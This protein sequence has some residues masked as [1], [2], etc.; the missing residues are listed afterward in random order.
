MQWGV[1]V[2][3]LPCAYHSEAGGGVLHCVQHACILPKYL[4]A[5][6]KPLQMVT[7]LLDP[8]LTHMEPGLHPDTASD[9][10]T[11]TVSSPVLPPQLMMLDLNSPQQWQPCPPDSS[12]SRMLDNMQYHRCKHRHSSR[13]GQAMSAWLPLWT[14]MSS[15][16]GAWQSTVQ[17]ARSAD[18]T[19]VPLTISHAADITLDGSSPALVIVY[20]A[21]GTSL[22]SQWELQ[23][24]PLLVR[25]WVICHAHV[26]GGK[27]AAY[28]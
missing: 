13:L 27:R 7:A 1:T 5:T 18:G 20:G 15:Q 23:H 19:A 22:D 17:Y 4:S 26:R 16:R 8:E 3:K 21:Y 2:L 25:G 10:I 11:V 6:S 9:T 24:L 28:I 12:S 14:S